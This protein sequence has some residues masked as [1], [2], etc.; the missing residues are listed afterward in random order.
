[1]IPVQG[2]LSAASPCTRFYDKESGS[3]LKAASRRALASQTARLGEAQKRAAG[4]AQAAQ[5]AD[6][7]YVAAQEQVQSLREQSSAADDRLSAAVARVEDSLATLADK[8]MANKA[9]QEAMKVNLLPFLRKSA[10]V[11]VYA[12]VLQGRKSSALW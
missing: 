11:R 10:A 8:E 2:V 4:A 3:M 7:A 9:A 12:A 6:D 1:M 5:S